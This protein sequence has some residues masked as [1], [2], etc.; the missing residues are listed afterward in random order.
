ML[1]LGGPPSSAAPASA[2]RSPARR[3][4]R[5]ELRRVLRRHPRDLLSLFAGSIARGARSGA[6]A[7]TRDRIKPSHCASACGWLVTSVSSPILVPS[8]ASRQCETGDPDL[9]HD[10]QA[11]AVPEQQVVDGV[12]RAPQEFSIGT[13][14][15]SAD[16]CAAAWKAPFKGPAW[17]GVAAGE[18]REG[19][20][21]GVGSGDALVG[22]ARAGARGGGGE[23]RGSG[24]GRGQAVGMAARDGSS[25]EEVL[26]PLLLQQLLPSGSRCSCSCRSRGGGLPSLLRREGDKG[27]RG[28]P[29]AGVGSGRGRRRLRR[30][31]RRRAV[32]VVVVAVD[33][34]A[35]ELRRR[36]F[37]RLPMK[38]PRAQKARACLLA[39]AAGLDWKADAQGRGCAVASM[40][41]RKRRRR[42][43]KTKFDVEAALPD[44][45]LNFRPVA[46]AL[47][48]R[49]A[50]RS[51]DDILIATGTRKKSSRELWVEEKREEEGRKSGDSS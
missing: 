45:A 21:L 36:R 12:D 2:A 25:E 20:G 15:A 9:A 40:R 18:S 38:E 27:R 10:A 35:T 16:H 31:R 30:S 13:T 28:G 19:R 22:D 51:A 41:R 48:P 49:E 23:E 7:Q 50:G 33:D 44:A 47:P 32:V 14:A 43:S 26:L 6:E 39:C 34:D 17:Q 11:V 1:R 46:A 37:P 4:L 29:P 42:L 3:E 5:G 24:R 8:G